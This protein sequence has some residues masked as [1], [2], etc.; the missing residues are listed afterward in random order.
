MLDHTGKADFERLRRRALLEKKISIVHAA[1]TDPAALFAFDV[2]VA[3]GKDVRK[4]PL[5]KRK[6]IVSVALKGSQRVRPVQYVGEQGTRLYE[7]AAALQL[8]RMVAKRADAPHKTRRSSDWLK[9]RTP[10]G[11]HVQENVQRSGISSEAALRGAG[12]WSR[13]RLMK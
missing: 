3:G 9:I 8:E 13:S 5:L 11:R 6:V 12:R 2:L 1:K 4:L 10:H 7:A